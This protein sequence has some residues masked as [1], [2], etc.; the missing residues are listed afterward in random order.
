MG[1][2]TPPQPCPCIS[3]SSVNL[4]RQLLYILDGNLYLNVDTIFMPIY[5]ESKYAHEMLKRH[6]GSFYLVLYFVMT[7]IYRNPLRKLPLKIWMIDIHDLYF[8]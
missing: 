3:H 8:H 6:W 7:V 1:V 4:E 2:R 5:V